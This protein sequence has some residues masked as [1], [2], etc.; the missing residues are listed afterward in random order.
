[1]LKVQLLSKHAKMP[2]RGSTFA[3]GYDLYAACDVECKGNSK[4]LIP[5]GIAVEIPP[6]YYGR[7]APRSGLS[8]TKFTHVGGGVVDEDYRGPLQVILFV[9]GWSGFTVKKGDRVAQL[10]ITPYASP[11]LVQVDQVSVSLRG[12][13]AF[14][15]TGE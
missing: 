14:G 8:W 15:S 6:G 11:E 9:L 5:L 13:G 12:D 4:N 3:A 7:I 2:T 1:M 10:I